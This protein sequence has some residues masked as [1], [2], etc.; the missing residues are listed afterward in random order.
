MDNGAL[1]DLDQQ[2]D[3]HVL[4]LGG[5]AALGAGLAGRAVAGIDTLHT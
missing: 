2:A 4:G 5:G 3:V 1:T